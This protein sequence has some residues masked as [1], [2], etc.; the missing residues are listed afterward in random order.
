MYVMNDIEYGFKDQNGKNIIYDKEKWNNEFYDFY[1]LQTP[2]E[3]LKTK[4]GVCWDQD[5]LKS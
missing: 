4:C 1:Y 3:L 5:E 2:N